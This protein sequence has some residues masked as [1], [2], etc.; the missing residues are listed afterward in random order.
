MT[1]WTALRIQQQDRSA[2][3]IAI[4]LS[5]FDQRRQNTRERIAANEVLDNSRARIELHPSQNESSI[6]SRVESLGGSVVDD[7]VF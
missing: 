7:A 6:S 4:Q 2:S 1:K 5:Q 3:S